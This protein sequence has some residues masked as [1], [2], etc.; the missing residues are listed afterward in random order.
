VS[1]G[2]F[3]EHLAYW[4]DEVKIDRYRR[5]LAATVEPGST[6][7]DLGTGTGLL[8]LLA[9]EAGA[10]HVY[11]VESGPI[12]AV[13]QEV[14]ARNG[15]SDRVSL[16]RGMSTDVRLTRNVDV[17]VGDQIGGLAYTAG[18]FTFY[19]DAARRF[20][21]PGGVCVPAGFELL[22][23]GAE[24]R[25]S[26]HAL[27]T[28]ADLQ[29]GFDLSALHDLA[30]HQPRVVTIEDASEMLTVPTPVLSRPSTDA[31]RFQ[32]STE[33]TVTREGTLDGIAGMFV[34]TMAPGVTMSNVPGHPDKLGRR[35]QDL[36]PV[37]GAVEVSEGDTV[38]VEMQV[39][40]RSYLATWQVAVE[41]SRGRVD[42]GRRSTFEG[43]ILDTSHVARLSGRPRA[44]SPL[45]REILRSLVDRIDDPVD[46]ADVV[47]DV[48]AALPGAERVAIDRV[49]RAAAAL[50]AEGPMDQ[51][52]L[53]DP[54]TGPTGP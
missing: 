9:C 16:L 1:S 31:S 42:L 3:D 5:A 8:A 25:T 28:Y 44:V 32:I 52:S 27:R 43:E 53:R 14:F 26:R 23:A 13:A 20:L 47:A 35:W 46:P 7:L 11:S 38:V 33:M 18:V 54:A 24:N 39:N 19:E 10:G 36:F 45:G 48:A 22:L 12:A 49:V 34:A 21:D 4:T 30:T 2:T 50:L 29:H 51:V 15:V 41:G 40:P 6:V 37:G 17:I